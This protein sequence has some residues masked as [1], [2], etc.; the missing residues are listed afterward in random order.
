VVAVGYLLGVVTVYLI[1]SV[2]AM[3]FNCTSPTYGANG[4]LIMHFILRTIE[5][6]RY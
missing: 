2:S 6:Q 1:T 3:P 5:L 4:N